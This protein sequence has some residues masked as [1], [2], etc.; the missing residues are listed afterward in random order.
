MS[1]PND[2]AAKVLFLSDRTCCV[3]RTKGK[4]VQIHH[5]DGDDKNNDLNNLAV[6]C[7]DCHL[8]TQIRGGFY[9]KLNAEQIKLYRNDWYSIVMSKREATKQSAVKVDRK[10]SIRWQIFTVKRLP[11]P[12]DLISKRMKS[13]PLRFFEP[14]ML[15]IPVCFPIKFKITNDGDESINLLTYVRSTMKAVVFNLAEP[16]RAWIWKP[17][18]HREMRK[19]SLD[20]E[21]RVEVPRKGKNQEFT[22]DAIYRPKFVSSPFLKR[23]ILEYHFDGRTPSGRKFVGGPYLIEIPIKT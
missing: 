23:V 15:Y 22:F 13:I 8:E 16:R 6:L 21:R 4:K 5:I 17:F 10:N 9:R 3:C 19:I 7:V 12:I 20:I 2:I 18:P 1:V 14:W 11:E